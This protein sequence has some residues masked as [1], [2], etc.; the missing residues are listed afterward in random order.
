MKLHK[1]LIMFGY[2]LRERERATLGNVGLSV[3]KTIHW[4]MLECKISF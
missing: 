1:K 4:H 3:I 2:I